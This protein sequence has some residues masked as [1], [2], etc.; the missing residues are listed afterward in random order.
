MSAPGPSARRIVIVGT[1]KAG[2]RVAAQL[3]AAGSTDAITLLDA[4]PYLPY[5]RPPLSKAFLQT[6]VATERD[7]DPAY[8]F[9]AS[10]YQ[11][12]RIDRQPGMTVN[13]I[14]RERQVVQSGGGVFA[15][16]TL[17]LATG[18]VA[19]VLSIP[20]H[21]LAGIHYLRNLDQ[22]CAL[23][24]AL[25][26]PKQLVVVGAGFI[27]LEVAASAVTQGCQVTVVESSSLAMGRAIPAA[28]A[29]PVLAEHHR[30]GVTVLFKAQV[31][32]FTGDRQI[33]GVQ[34]ADGHILPCDA[35]V[36]GIG[37]IPAS[38]LAATAGL[39]CQDGIVVDAHFKTSDPNIY[40]VGD[41]CRFP[42]PKNGELIRLESWRNADEQASHLASILMGSTEPFN[43][44]PFFWSDQYGLTL[45]IVGHPAQG[46]ATIER[47]LADGALIQFFTD[48]AGRLVGAGAWGPLAHIGKEIRA[49]EHLIRRGVKATPVALTN[50]AVSLKSLLKR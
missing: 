8:L 15:Y 49:A 31:Q 5:D 1:G 3:R 6:N 44:L 29:A 17:V 27:G 26:R 28:L 22:A 32:A 11:D 47:R 33:S 20:G 12:Q 16:D 18:A 34:I 36:I 37:A 41:A 43:G 39:H 45:Q 19:R 40:A 21:D 50:P 42:D 7:I 30:R 38:A 13:A 25:S 24:A 2:T 4:E 46:I 9:P 10:F 23:R 35:A 14:D 48:T